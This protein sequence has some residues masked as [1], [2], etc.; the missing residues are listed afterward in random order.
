MCLL[1]YAATVSRARLE[2]MHK[3]LMKGDWPGKHMLCTLELFQE[4]F[5]HEQPRHPV[6]TPM[7]LLVAKVLLFTPLRTTHDLA[8][9]LYLVKI[10]ET[11]VLPPPLILSFYNP[12][13]PYLQAVSSR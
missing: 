11:Y 9:G 4:I 10:M 2:Q 8:R 13:Q 6:L 3:R 12:L 1:R 7:L 5:D